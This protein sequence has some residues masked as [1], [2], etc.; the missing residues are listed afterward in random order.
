M[1]RD[2]LETLINLFIDGR[3]AG[4]EVEALSRELESREDARALYLSIVRMHAAL[5]DRGAHGP[6][7]VNTALSLRRARRRSD[8]AG[9]LRARPLAAG[10]FWLIDQGRTIARFAELENCRWV[11]P[12]AD[13]RAGEPIRKGRMVELAS[14]TAHIVFNTGARVALLG[15]CIFEVTSSKGGFLTLGQMKTVAATPESKGFTIKT[16]TARIV[17]VGTEFVTSAALDGQSRI[18]VTS[19]EVFVHLRG[20]RDPQRLRTGEALSVEAGRTQIMVRIESGDDTASFNFPTIEPPTSN[21]YA[22]ASR[23]FASIRVVH[24]K[25]HSTAAIPSGPPDILL[26]GRGQ[27]APDSPAESVF[28]ENDAIGMLLLDLGV[29]ISVSKINTYS[30]HRDRG[31]GENRV[32]A[33]QK[34]ML[35]GYAG[36]KPPP[37]EQSLADAGWIPLARVNSDDFFNVK[38]RVDR[39]AQQACSITSA[40]GPIGRYRYLLW[41][42]EPSQSPTP[43]RFNNAF[44]SEFD[45]YGEP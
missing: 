11:G 31:D 30:W 45:I 13:V 18:D 17:D 42:V 33:A 8:V 40:H 6:E 15:P 19:G 22:D 23:G 3:A 28:F 43:L 27:S 21:D 35:Y 29:S 24:G 14:G 44:Y 5:V 2:E 34:Y 41:R 26:N 38:A 39:P 9:L 12:G 25:L 7:R 36:E 16:R 32:R 37:V 20:V 10:G 1:S 4:A